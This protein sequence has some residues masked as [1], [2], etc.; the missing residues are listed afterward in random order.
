MIKEN[1]VALFLA[2]VFWVPLSLTAAQAQNSSS[3]QPAD[4]SQETSQNK[5]Y[6]GDDLSWKFGPGFGLVEAKGYKTEAAFSV[7][8]EMANR[9]WWG[10]ATI[11]N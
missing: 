3:S 8:V 9:L 1:A 6:F 11:S 4:T 5:L 10:I 7:N 2:L